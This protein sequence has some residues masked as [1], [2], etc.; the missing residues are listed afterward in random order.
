MLL[1]HLDSLLQIGVC[2]KWGIYKVELF[3]WMITDVKSPAEPPRAA[4]REQKSPVGIEQSNKGSSRQQLV[5]QFVVQSPIIGA[6]KVG[7][8]SSQKTWYLEE[9]FKQE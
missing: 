1:A 4:T 6:E 5:S 2:E 9:V 7:L 3:S 8:F